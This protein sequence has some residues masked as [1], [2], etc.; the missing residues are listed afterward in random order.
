MAKATI[1]DSIQNARTLK[2]A[3]TAAVQ[4]G[5]V[6]VSNGQ[7]LVAVNDAQAN[8]ENAYVYM[9][10]VIAPKVAGTA[11]AP[12]DKAYWDP[13]AGNM[14]KT[15]SGNTLCAMCVEAAL[16]ADAQLVAFLRPNWT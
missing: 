1:A 7:V 14:T 16:A 5:D 8:A 4:A 11:F 13:A 3:H 15:T 10:K 6:I 12:G 9:G 2:L